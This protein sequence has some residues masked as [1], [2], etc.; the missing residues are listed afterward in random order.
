LELICGTKFLLIAFI[1]KLFGRERYIYH[2]LH[3]RLTHLLL[4]AKNANMH[5]CSFEVSK[6]RVF[7]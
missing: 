7:S 4:E 5:S 2:L 1:D 3:L 6:M